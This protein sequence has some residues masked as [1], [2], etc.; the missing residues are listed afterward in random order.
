MSYVCSKSKKLKKKI[1]QNKDKCK[2]GTNFFLYSSSSD[3]N[4]YENIKAI[5]KKIRNINDS[6]SLQKNKSS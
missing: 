5:R 4:E 3:S 2:Y 6:L 1:N